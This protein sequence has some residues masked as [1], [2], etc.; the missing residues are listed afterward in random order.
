MAI[1]HVYLNAVH[2][3]PQ[4]LDTVRRPANA[5][6]RADTGHITVA[7]PGDNK[8]IARCDFALLVELERLRAWEASNA[9]LGHVLNLVV[10]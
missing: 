4:P 1:R 10:V 7:Q 6:D 5:L 8:P 2:F 9:F 3:D